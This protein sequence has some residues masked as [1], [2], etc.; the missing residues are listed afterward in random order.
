MNNLK[1][2][3]L[4]GLLMAFC[5][6][7][8]RLYGGTQGLVMAFIFGSVGNIFAYWFSDKII[9]WSSGAREVSEADLPR[10]YSIVRN[11]SQSAGIPVP[12][13]YLMDTDM[14]NAFATGRSPGHAAVAV[15]SGILKVLDERELTGVLAHELSHVFNRDILISTVAS[16][17]A[18][19]I[20]MLAR[21]AQWA[22]IFGGGRDEEDRGA[23]P[24]AM[25]ALAIIAPLAAML[26]QMAISRS[27]EYA[28]DAA[29]SGLTG[30]PAGLAMALGKI[31]RFAGHIPVPGA[32]PTTA[33]LYII[34]PFTVSG[35]TKLFSTHPPTEERIA[36][37]EK[38]AGLR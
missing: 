5:L 13:V 31:Q 28:A 25:I 11:L 6:A 27:R 29:A 19:A 7:V 8:G 14:P 33:H 20:Y 37:L 21:M 18:G 32:S 1:T 38:M 17:M 36:R 2:A 30:D 26:I 4:M 22:A 24:V 16:V 34:N 15:T 3:F 10:V 35:I 12:K 9:L 23:N